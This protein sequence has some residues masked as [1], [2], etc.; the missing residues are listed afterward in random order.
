MSKFCVKCR[1]EINPQRLKAIPSTTV[2]VN[3]SS[4]G[5][6][7]ALVTTNGEG[8]HTW[9]DIHIVTQEQCN[10]LSSTTLDVV[11]SN[12]ESCE[13][14]NW[15]NESNVREDIILNKIITVD[16]FSKIIEDEYPE[17]WEEDIEGDI[18]DY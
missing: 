8:D 13:M 4:I 15:D 11:D 17:E 2:C 6:Y 3:C 9:N 1:V 14:V 10:L 7:K 12:Q 5:A 16:D 18:N